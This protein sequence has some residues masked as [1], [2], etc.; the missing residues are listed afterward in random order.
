MKPTFCGAGEETID[1]NGAT[2]SA[3]SIFSNIEGL[4]G[5]ELNS[6]FKL[7]RVAMVWRAVSSESSKKVI[8]M[9]EAT[10]APRNEKHT[11]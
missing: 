2:N 3:V 10:G 7:E 1:G 11:D 8:H 5:L 4:D 9:F 6:N